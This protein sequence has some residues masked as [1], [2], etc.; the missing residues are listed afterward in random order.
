MANRTLEWVIRMVDK[1]SGPAGNAGSSIGKMLRQVDNAK[2]AAGAAD[3]TMSQMNK[4]VGQVAAPAAKADTAL[5]NMTK[6]LDEAKKA[7]GE[8]G[9]ALQ[10]MEKA[11]GG[12]ATKHALGGEA[13]GEMKKLMGGVFGSEGGQLFGGGLRAVLGSSAGEA[14]GL[15]SGIGA[16]VAAALILVDVFK[17]VG[18]LI[19]EGIRKVIEFTRELTKTAVE[20][21]AFKETTLI[22]LGTVLGSDAK[23]K[24][25]FGSTVK[26]TSG[27]PLGTEEALDIQKRFAIGGFKGTPTLQRMLIAA[28]DV[29]AMRGEE[30]LETFT[31]QIT[32]IA[33][34][35]LQMGHL[36]SLAQ[37]SGIQTSLIF[38]QLRKMT[39]FGG[40]D[41]Q[42]EELISKGGIG[43]GTAVRAIIQAL[44]VQ[45]N[46]PLGTLSLRLADTFSGLVTKFKSA[47]FNMFLDFD[48]AP[49]FAAIKGALKG[50]VEM[51]DP[52]KG[53][54]AQLKASL[55]KAISGILTAIF[56]DLSPGRIESMLS[57]LP[58]TIEVIGDVLSG[59]I[60]SVKSFA[61][62]FMDSAWPAIRSL[63]DELGGGRSE[64][65]Q[66]MFRLMGKIIGRFLAGMLEMTRDAMKVGT[67][68]LDPFG[69]GGPSSGHDASAGA[70]PRGG[71]P[72][73]TIERSVALHV[74]Q[75]FHVTGDVRDVEPLASRLK[76]EGRSGMQSY[77][78]S[79]ASSL[80]GAH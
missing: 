8:T 17:E 9:A 25:L 16:A 4:V 72:G 54:G 37:G 18:N 6:Q 78:T 42:L 61:E 57:G 62:G 13:A 31:R 49:G 66:E 67:F 56:G 32:D 73:S 1:M 26:L 15:A 70:P 22:G 68:M 38:R 63:I 12:E 53:I 60:T 59:V 33:N 36:N 7:A 41:H 3:S 34:I 21:A 80:V 71:G 79:L 27:L 39:G 43:K 47:L 20:T 65:I 48:S 29:K 46:G 30:G 24:A 2:R 76:E 44:A 58:S 10:K 45:E 55:S 74:E 14:L 5:G 19:S 50:L 77:L 28:S 40:T 64:A 52:S 51:L 75:H 69:V 23:G 11:V 35:G